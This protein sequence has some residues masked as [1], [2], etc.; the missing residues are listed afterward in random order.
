MKL[1]LGVYQLPEPMGGTTF[2]VAEILESKYGLFSHFSEYAEES[3]SDSIENS[4]SMAIE[5]L[6]RG[7]DVHSLTMSGEEEVIVQFHQFLDK[8]I[9]ASLGVDGVPTQAALNGVNHRLKSKNGKRRPSFIDTGTLRD[10]FV[11]WAE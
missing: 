8:E 3:I 5:A 2:D 4:I 9:M 1:L 11:C 7:E 10:S 6:N